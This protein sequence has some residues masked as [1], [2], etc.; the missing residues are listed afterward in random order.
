M[1]LTYGDG[2]PLGIEE[3]DRLSFRRR[4]KLLD[5][6]NKEREREAAYYKSIKTK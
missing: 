6:V 4:Y 3:F 2:L 5:L 1:N